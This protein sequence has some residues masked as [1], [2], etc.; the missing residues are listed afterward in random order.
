MDCVQPMDCTTN[1]VYNIGGGGR[2]A[3]IEGRNEL[4]EGIQGKNELKEGI[5]GKKGLKERMN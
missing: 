3:R 4:K 1:G 2:K 5:H